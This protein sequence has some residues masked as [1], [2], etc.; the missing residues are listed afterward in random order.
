MKFINLTGSVID[1]RIKKGVHFKIEPE[2]EALEIITYED[3]M[4]PAEG[5]KD[6]TTGELIP[7][8]IFT[9]WGATY[10]PNLP[11]PVPGTLYIVTR[12]V[13][14]YTYKKNRNDFV[15]TVNNEYNGV[16][17]ALVSIYYLVN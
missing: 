3:E 6:D 15:T 10:P 16:N 13:L 5:I 8:C 11:D 4:E 7:S 14:E 12:D 9:Q 17:E 1:I 2:P